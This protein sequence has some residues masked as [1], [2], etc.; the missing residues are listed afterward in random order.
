MTLDEFNKRIVSHYGETE[1][2][3]G[4]KVVIRTPDGTAYPLSF[5]PKWLESHIKPDG[6]N[7][8]GIPAYMVELCD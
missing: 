7:S 1:I 2:V 6:V 3:F 8:G 5:V 4:S